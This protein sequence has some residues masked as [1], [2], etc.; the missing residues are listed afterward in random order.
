MTLGVAS[1]KRNRYVARMARRERNREEVELVRVERTVVVE[2]PAD[3]VWPS[4][5][6]LDQLAD[7]LGLTV[8]GDDLRPDD[9][10]PDDRSPSRW[11]R[12][13]VWSNRTAP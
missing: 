3:R 5:A 2:A 13:L 1:S 4:V 7:W 12:P 10:R 9:L 11:A 8:D 6:R